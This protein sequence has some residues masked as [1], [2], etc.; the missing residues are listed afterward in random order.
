MRADFWALRALRNLIG[1]VMAIAAAGLSLIATLYPDIPIGLIRFM[2][3][4]VICSGI[5]MAVAWM[6]A[7]VSALIRSRLQ[8][9]R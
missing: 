9:P 1:G 3:L 7:V 8:Q 4:A 6:G 2:F 5:V